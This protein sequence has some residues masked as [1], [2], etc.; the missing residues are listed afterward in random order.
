MAGADPHPI[1]GNARM[2]QLSKRI[3]AADPV[4]AAA[5]QTCA[6]QS[7][8]RSYEWLLVLATDATEQCGYFASIS[9]ADGGVAILGPRTVWR[10]ERR[11]AFTTDALD[12]LVHWHVPTLHVLREGVRGAQARR[13]RDMRRS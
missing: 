9:R 12:V 6:L 7:S 13:R 1:P 5:A 3:A 10:A 2:R 4:V 8:R 11:V